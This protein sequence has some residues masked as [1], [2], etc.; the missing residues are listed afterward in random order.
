MLHLKNG[1]GSA[2]CFS[3]HIDNAQYSN[4]TIYMND[5][6]V[7]VDISCSKAPLLFIPKINTSGDYV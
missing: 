4:S 3:F 7:S 1:I 2:Y 6:F 5:S